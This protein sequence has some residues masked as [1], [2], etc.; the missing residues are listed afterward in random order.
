M[1]RGKHMKNDHASCGNDPKAPKKLHK[2]QRESQERKPEE[3]ITY[4]DE[5]LDGSDVYDTAS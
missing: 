1:K 4:S 2:P 5:C 3:V